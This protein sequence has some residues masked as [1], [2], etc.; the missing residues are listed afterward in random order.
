MAITAAVDTLTAFDELTV[1]LA[2]RSYPIRV[3]QAL[4]GDVASYAGAICGPDVV[5]VSNETVAPLYLPRVLDALADYRVQT[6]ILPDGERFKTFDNAMTIIDAALEGGA[7]RDTTFIA[8]G[9]G[10]VGD[11]TGF[12]AACFM[13]GVNFV[14]LPTTLLAQVDSSVGGKTG[15]NHPVG[16]NLIGAFHQPVRVIIDTD[17][18]ATLPA[19]EYAAGLAEVIKY[20]AIVDAGF[21][22]WLAQ[23]MAQLVAREPKALR[24]A[25]MTSCR[26]KAEIVASDERERGKRALLNFGHTFGHAI[27]A[28]TQYSQWLH[29]EAVAN[30]MLLAVRMSNIGQDAVD[31][32]AGVLD[33]AGLPHISDDIPADK[34]LSAMGHDKKVQAGRIRLVLLRSLGDAYVADDYDDARLLR[35]LGGEDA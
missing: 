11:M 22:D 31:R 3:G 7:A 18:L 12:A 21:L 19:R 29:G 34:L 5:V 27:E 20:G 28:C 23:N 13:R 9:G 25:I 10:V 30:G 35:V 17:T 26:I 33:A 4:L 32:L 6:C 24:H 2:E 8:L 1:E 15:V 16:K 14:Q